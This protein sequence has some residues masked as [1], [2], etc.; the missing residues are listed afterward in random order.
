M[1]DT[2]ATDQPPAAP[3]KTT[4]PRFLMELE[5]VLSLANPY[6]LSHL[7]VTY[8]HLLSEPAS[9]TSATKRSNT[10]TQDTP[11]KQ[12]AAYLKYLYNYWRDPEYSRYLTHPGATLRALEL[13]QQERFR[14]EIIM[15]H[16]IE[17]LLIGDQALPE[18][19][20][21]TVEGE[22]DVTKNQESP[23]SV[24]DTKMET[25]AG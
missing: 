25:A 23:A 20:K 11:A 13:L 9:A 15:P 6:Y 4:S 16:V 17:R 24:S 8:P 14:K 21:I 2:M 3:P 19:P 7:A 18:Q 12:F 22:G 10:S 5:F 1:G